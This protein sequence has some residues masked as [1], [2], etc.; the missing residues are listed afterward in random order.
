MKI[1]SKRIKQ[2]YEKYGSLKSLKLFRV[3]CRRLSASLKA[4]S[5]RLHS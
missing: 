4:Q 5:R 1:D 3:N 2:L